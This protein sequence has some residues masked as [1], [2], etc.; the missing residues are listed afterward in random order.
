MLGQDRLILAVA[1]RLAGVHQDLRVGHHPGPDDP[2]SEQL[3]GQ[4]NKQGRHHGSADDPADNRR[5]DP[6]GR[7][8]FQF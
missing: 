7:R 1:K 8:L 6:S 5:P 3:R 4:E 2:A